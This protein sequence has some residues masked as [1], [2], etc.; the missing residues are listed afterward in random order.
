MPLS[1]PLTKNQ[2]AHYRAEGYIL[3]ASVLAVDDLTKID[4]AIEEVVD[5]AL[6]RD[7]HAGLLELEPQSGPGKPAVRRICDPYDRHANF[8]AV[9]GDSRILDRV[10]S[11]LGPDLIL[12]HSKL[13]M[14]PAGVGSP[15]KWHQDLAYYPHT[16]DDVL[17][18][19]IYLDDA[20][21][22]NG[23]L[24]V[25]AGAHDKYLNHLGPDGTFDGQ[26]RE[27]RD[28][29]GTIQPLSAPA[30]SAIFMHGLLPHSSLPNRS[31]RGRRTL[32]FAYRAAD[33]LPLYYGQVTAIDEA[34][35]RPIRGRRATHARF[36]GPPPIVPSIDGSRSLYELQA[37]ESSAK[38][39]GDPG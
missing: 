32:I 31:D 35:C 15:V 39:D 19:L 27:T 3:A 7:D 29:D 38:A 22:E 12:Q 6:S 18:V 25:M 34:G 13:N 17:A 30:G 10:E 36:G 37:S 20:D 26:L 21:E 14:K 1:W 9:A 24:Q 5:A 4:C 8:R 16:N 23:C 33:A 2:I 28:V 11:L